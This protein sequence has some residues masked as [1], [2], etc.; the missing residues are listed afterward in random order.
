MLRLRVT[1]TALAVM[2]ILWFALDSGLLSAVRTPPAASASLL[3]LALLFG[4]GAW[5]MQAGGRGERS[6]LLVGL[7]LGVG[8]YAVVRL[9]P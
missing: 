7:S 8:L 6:P 9:I 4:V 1:A 5:G 3:T 2:G